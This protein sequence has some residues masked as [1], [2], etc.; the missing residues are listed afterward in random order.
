MGFLGLDV[1]AIRHL[2]RQLDTQAA[3]VDTSIREM[4]QLIR[5]TEWYGTDSRR[6]LE[7]WESTHAAELRRAAGL[8]REA[9]QLAARGASQQEQTSRG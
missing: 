7:Q 5:T 9:S 2:S 4:D 6:F 8:L 3:E 1:M